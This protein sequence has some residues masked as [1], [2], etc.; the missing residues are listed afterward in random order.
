TTIGTH[1][2]GATMRITRYR[3][4]NGLGL[5]LLSDGSAPVACYQTWFAV[6]SRHEQQGKTGIAHFLEHLMFN[7]TENVPY[8]EF[9][10]RLELVGADTN[11]A[12]FLDW[13]YYTV[14]LPAEALPTIVEL[15][16]DRMAN[17]VLRDPQVASE[18]EVV[19]NER[20]QTVDDDV[21]G[22]MTERLY[23]EAFRQHGYRWP[24]IG[25]MADIEGLST[26]DC[27]RQYQTFYAP[28]N[29]TLVVTGD[30]DEAQLLEL[31]EQHYGQLKPSAL[32]PDPGLVE[33]VQEAERRVTMRLPTASAKVAM[34]YRCPAMGDADHPTL[35][36]LNEILFGGRASR[37]HRRLVQELEI[38]SEVHG[39]IGHFQDPSL[40]D[41]YLTVRPGAD[42]GAVQRALDEVLAEVVT[43]PV[44]QAE[45]ERA[46]ARVELATLQGLETAAGKAEQ[47]GFYDTVLGDPGALFSRLEAFRSAGRDAIHEAA[48]RYLQ[49]RSRTVV[50]VHPAGD[51]AP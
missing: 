45:V 43:G 42:S 47:I 20:R 22:A 49:T 31:V 9:D 5:L 3:L 15:E 12:T 34:G 17:L 19:V 4:D 39:S 41:I 23:C 27:Q 8:G 46:Q 32:P 44:T 13:T 40:Y 10:R 7:E 11:A 24:T 2:F 37:V 16:S 18:R 50:E 26:A 36:L 51:Q 6:G 25:F 33:P 35:V 21:D 28:N 48:K 30:V 1:T 29:A 38:A 14:S